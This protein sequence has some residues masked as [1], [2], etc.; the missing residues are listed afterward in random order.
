MKEIYLDNSATTKISEEALSA[1]MRAY[2][3]FGN[4][5]SLHP[6][7]QR[8]TKVVRSASNVILS[9]LEGERHTGSVYF[10]SGG[11]EANNLAII[12]GFL[13]KQRKPG[14]TVLITD[15]E[16]A[17]VEEAAF[18][19]EKYGARIVKIP[20]KAG[21]LDLE[22]LEK[23]LDSSVVMASFMTVNNETGAVYDIPKAFEIIKRKNPEVITHT[24]AVQAFGKL[25][26]FAPRMKA[27]MITASSH[28]IH[29][30]MGVG[31]LYVSKEILVRRKL[32]PIVFG[33]GQMQGFRS[34]T[35]NYP[36]I[37]GFSAAA[38]ALK[39]NL[40]SDAQTMRSLRDYAIEK[41][42]R[43]NVKLNLPPIA[44]PHILSITLPGIK[45]EVMLHFLSNYGICVSS[46]SAC[47]SNHPNTSRPLLSFGLSAFDA[48]C[49]VRVSLSRCNTKEEIDVF[50]DALEKGIENLVRRKK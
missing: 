22:F 6:V 19:L 34:G 26:V 12:G 23:V 39:A 10:T 25:P 42:S 14:D 27:D 4:P 47:S 44:A 9:L 29:G 48:D 46:G 1:V 8:A 3:D 31:V 36:G 15:S 5:S 30:P 50:T 13:S 11:T 33:G 40:Q 2:S 18:H 43:L 21:V 49:T 20:T 28:K 7:G 45:S 16:H 17:S 24:D 38:E 35:E 37:A 41:L 32:S